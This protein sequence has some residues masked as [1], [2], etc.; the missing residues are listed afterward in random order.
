ME[1]QLI[2]QL[3]FERSQEAI[4]AVE[5]K[6]GVLCKTIASRILKN[7]Q[8]AEECVNDTLLAAWNNIPPENPDPLISYIC[9][10]TRN[11]ALKRYTQN[12]AQKRNHFYDVT[13]D[14]LGDTLA[15]TCSVEKEY[16]AEELKKAMNHFLSKQKKMD[17]I[18]FVK[19]YWFM[20]SISEIA[21]CYG[22]S[23]NYVTVHL[24]RTREKLKKYLT[25]EGLI[26]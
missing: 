9:K 4:T 17:C 15:G 10:I 12:T 26:Q 3:F 14:E 13:L 23:N 8:D 11:L 7:E 18:F 2:I 6:Y 25:K 20:E 16:M 22:K 19:R 21:E 1:D 24:H 5:G